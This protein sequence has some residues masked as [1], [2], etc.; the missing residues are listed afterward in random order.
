MAEPGPSRL[1]LIVL[2]AIAIVAAGLGA[3]GVNYVLQPKATS[4]LLTVA[5]GD[6][7]TVN[8]IGSFGSGAQIGRTFDTSIYSVYANN[9]TYPKSLQFASTHN[10]SPLAYKPLDVHVGGAGQYTIGNLT[11][12]TT[13]TGFWQGL[14]GMNGNQTRFL[15]IPPSL[16]YG[17]LNPACTQTLPLT[18]TVPVV[19]VAPASNF[20][21]AY[22]GSSLTAGTTFSD[23]TYKWT[24]LVLSVNATSVVVERLTSIGQTTLG[25]SGW[26]VTVT[27]LTSTT[28]TLQNDLTTGNYGR[29]LGKFSVARGCPPGAQSSD[30]SFEILDVNPG[31]GTY[32]INWNSEVTG[33][34]L[35]FQVTIVDILKG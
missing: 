16:G 30:T 21:T 8:Y 9:I 12:G 1:W 32:T 29:V 19:F 10:G 24:D 35:L 2:I 7:V 20:T 13:V 27:Q 31:A 4:S 28:I 26:N 22:P 5:A 6:N 33:Q 18:L 23:P 11:F 15:S 17:P 3:W 34:T 25:A 14:I